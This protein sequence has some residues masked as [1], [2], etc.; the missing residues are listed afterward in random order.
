MGHAIIEAAPQL[1]LLGGGVA[2][3]IGLIWIGLFK[4]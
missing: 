2:T 3:A 1:G 4:N